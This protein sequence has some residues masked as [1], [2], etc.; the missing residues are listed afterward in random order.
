MGRGRNKVRGEKETLKV[1]SD[2]P[3]KKNKLIWKNRGKYSFDKLNLKIQKENKGLKKLGK[4]KVP[5]FEGLAV[6]EPR[7]SSCRLVL[8]EAVYYF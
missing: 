4:L 3:R 5:E 6:L 1:P 2:R 7:D 8:S